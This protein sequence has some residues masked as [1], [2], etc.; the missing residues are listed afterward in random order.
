MFFFLV[1]KGGIELH[2]THPAREAD[3]ATLSIEGNQPC[4]HFE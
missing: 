2:A 3:T 1:W 4:I